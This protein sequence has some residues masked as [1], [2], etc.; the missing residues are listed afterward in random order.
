MAKVNVNLSIFVIVSSPKNNIKLQHGKACILL[1]K[2]EGWKV[3][4]A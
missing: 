1:F 3:V 2:Q 4:A